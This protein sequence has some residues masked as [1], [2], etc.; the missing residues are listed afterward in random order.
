MQEH[1]AATQNG[2]ERRE[3]SLGCKLKIYI[4]LFLWFLLPRHENEMS[5]VR[6]SVVGS[7]LLVCRAIAVLYVLNWIWTF[8]FQPSVHCTMEAINRNY[9]FQR[10]LSN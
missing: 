8:S 10:K 3:F 4:K 1:A 9:N 5:G 2:T 7:V 6:Q